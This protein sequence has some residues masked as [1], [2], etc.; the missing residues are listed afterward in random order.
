VE[1]LR[2][3]TGQILPSFDSFA[4]SFQQAGLLK[5]VVELL[6]CSEEGNLPVEWWDDPVS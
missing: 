4:A 2:E 1:I 6:V 5:R 3:F